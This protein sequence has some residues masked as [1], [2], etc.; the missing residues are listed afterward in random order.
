VQ[1]GALTLEEKLPGAQDWH[2]R[3]LFST[4]LVQGTDT[5]SPAEQLRHAKH[6]M[7]SYAEQLVEMYWSEEVG[8]DVEHGLHSRLV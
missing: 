5:Y 6:L 3:F 4:F 8:Q 7:L 2:S 1:P